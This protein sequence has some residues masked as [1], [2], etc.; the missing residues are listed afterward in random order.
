MAKHVKRW[1][2]I[3]NFKT[4]YQFQ[5]PTPRSTRNYPADEPDQLPL[6]PFHLPYR[7]LPPP[8]P[9]T[10]PPRHI[11]SPRLPYIPVFAGTLTMTAAPQPQAGRSR[12]TERGP[13]SGQGRVAPF[14]AYL[15]C[16]SV[17]KQCE[18][19]YNNE[20][21]QRITEH[22]AEERTF[23]SIDTTKSINIWV[24]ALLLTIVRTVKQM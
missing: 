10:P 1:R 19:N 8:P 11:P 18:H 13:G 20:R 24:L 22:R 15:S 14:T 4:P 16:L 6:L 7:Q 5:F 2:I 9:P 12:E 3:L 17:G 21:C 23:A